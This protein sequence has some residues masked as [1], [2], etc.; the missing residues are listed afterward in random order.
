MAAALAEAVPS[1][2]ESHC[3]ALISALAPALAHQHSRVRSAATEALFAL[4]LH[5]PS[6]LP[7]VAPQLALISVG[8]PSRLFFSSLLSPFFS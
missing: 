7:E 4:L 1:H 3:Q 2:I 8:N 5:E 6:M